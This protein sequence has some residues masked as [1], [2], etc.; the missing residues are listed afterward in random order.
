[1]YDAAVVQAVKS[2]QRAYCYDEDGV[3]APQVQKAIAYEAQRV[4]ETFGEAGYECEWAD[5]PLELA[6]AAAKSGVKVRQS[7]SQDRKGRGMV[8]GAQRRQRGLCQEQ[9]GG[10]L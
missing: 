7:A 8:P 5:E 2:F 9:P 6:R 1:M 4:A 10:I 3:A